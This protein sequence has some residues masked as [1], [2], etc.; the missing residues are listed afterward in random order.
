MRFQNFDNNDE[1][2]STFDLNAILKENI[3]FR[4]TY[5]ADMVPLTSLQSEQ[6][7]I[8]NTQ[9]NNKPGEDWTALIVNKS[10]CIFF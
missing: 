7:F 9:K 4:G 1:I 2:L 5:A 6:A 8:I 10:S 3:I